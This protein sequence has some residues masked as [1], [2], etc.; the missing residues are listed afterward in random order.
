M[1]GIVGNR[2]FQ[3]IFRE[4]AGFRFPNGGITTFRAIRRRHKHSALV[5]NPT[6]W[7]LDAPVE[8]GYATKGRAEFIKWAWHSG[9]S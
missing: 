2:T 4:S 3:V 1:K 6:S 7:V 8:S 5:N 9:W